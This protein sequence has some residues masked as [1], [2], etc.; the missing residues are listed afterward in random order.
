MGAVEIHLDRRGLATTMGAVEIHL[1]RRGLA[2]EDKERSSSARPSRTCMNGKRLG[3]FIALGAGI[4]T[5][6]GS[7]VHQIPYGLAFGVAIGVALGSFA[8]QQ[9]RQK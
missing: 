9:R 3:L 5:A 1:D 6:I 2:I 7:A 8:D 4:G